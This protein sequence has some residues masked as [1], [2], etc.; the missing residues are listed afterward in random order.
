MVNSIS[1]IAGANVQSSPLSNAALDGSMGK[2]AFLKLLVAQM[3]AQDPMNPMESTDFSAQLAQFSGLEQMQNVNKNLEN[4]INF[5]MTN[6]NNM[7]VNLIDKKVMVPGNNNLKIT[8]GKP[9]SLSY[10]LGRNAALVNINVYDSKNNLVTSIDKIQES[11][12]KHEIKWDGKNSA[13]EILPDGDYTFQLS[14]TDSSNF[15]VAVRTVKE[16]LVTGVL[17]ENGVSYVVTEDGDTIDL[18]NITEV[19]SSL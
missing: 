18:K 10:E 8:A 5:Q 1:N 9:D 3:S 15:P 4:L 14:A 17:F 13:G 2:D 11:A 6:N 7:T 16:A 19:K 12:G